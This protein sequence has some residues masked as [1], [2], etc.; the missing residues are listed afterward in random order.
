MSTFEQQEYKNL[1]LAVFANLIDR[2]GGSARVWMNEFGKHLLDDESIMYHE[3]PW[4]WI[5]PVVAQHYGKAVRV[6]DQETARQFWNK[7]EKEL[8]TRLFSNES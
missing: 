4:H 7:L 5:V 8:H 2:T 1:W 6:L 3:Y